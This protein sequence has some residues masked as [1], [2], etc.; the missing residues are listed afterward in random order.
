MSWDYV[1][2]FA[3]LKGTVAVVTGAAGGIGTDVTEALVNLGVTVVAG[4]VQPESITATEQVVPV[5]ADV[6]SEE[7]TQAL[8]EAVE[9]T[10]RRLSLWLNNA[11]A[12]A[13]GTA[14]DHTLA[15]FD[16][17]MDVN[18]R[19]TFLGSRA[20]H[21]LMSPYGQGAIVNVASLTGT[22]V[23][24]GRPVYGPS[25]AAVASLTA[26][27]GSEWGPTGVTVNAI[28]AGYVD[29]SMSLW[30]RLDEAGRTALLDTIPQRRQGQP[31]DITSMVITLA[32]PLTS[33]VT[34]QTI[35]VDGGWTL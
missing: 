16:R 25:K 2:P 17:V 26:Y 3:P 10:G 27:L 20:A 28:A 19:G 15:D 12:I 35:H 18:V 30:Y 22:R 4:D 6:S 23:Q 8:V 31:K 7:G 5:R 24:Q 9:G 29:T 14:H 11:G 13:R 32:S 1:Q 34:G 21:R 33:Y